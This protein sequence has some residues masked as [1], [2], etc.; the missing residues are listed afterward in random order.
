M[1]VIEDF[2]SWTRRNA[3]P[4]TVFLIGSLV[5]SGF[6]FLTTNLNGIVYLVL[7]NGLQ[8]RPWTCLTY[9]WAVMPFGN[10]IQL[11]TFAFVM[12]WLFQTGS[13]VERE[14]GTPRF[15]A[16]WFAA[17]A[18]PGLLITL[19]ASA[20]R[21]PVIVN[22]PYL[23]IFAV[24][25]IWCIRNRSATI[26]LF[27]FIPLQAI[28]LAWISGIAAFFI[29]G[30]PQSIIGLL[31]CIHL[32]VAALYALDKIPFLLYGG[33]S[34]IVSSG[35]RVPGNRKEATTR[36]QVMYDQSYFDEVKRRETERAEQER[37]KK[38]FGED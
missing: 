9:P 25:V 11:I 24:T 29:Y 38:L 15:A 26:M 30:G 35:R 20:M 8:G 5:A 32:V 1:G 28:W 12:F 37:L 31:A 17:T 22:A 33:G 23:P 6:I 27:G 3:A 36:G 19:G 7:S 2:T 4:F 18:L 10:G 16:L 13:S 21:H 34:G 14:I